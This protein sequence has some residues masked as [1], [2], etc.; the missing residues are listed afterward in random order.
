[1][2]ITDSSKLLDL[3]TRALLR[4][5]VGVF[6]AQATKVADDKTVF[7]WQV[8]F[9]KTL[10]NFHQAVVRFGKS[11]SL[12]HTHRLYTKLTDTTPHTTRERFSSIIEFETGGT[13]AFH[14]NPKLP[15]AVDSAKIAADAYLRSQNRT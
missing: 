7:V 6:Y 15:A 2:G 12:F 3:A 5:A 8:A 14:I 13:A 11:I 9:H 10:T 1:M 4:H